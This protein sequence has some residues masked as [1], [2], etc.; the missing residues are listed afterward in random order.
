MEPGYFTFK[1]QSRISL[2]IAC[3]SL[4]IY[5]SLFAAEVM[6]DDNKLV[7]LPTPA[8]RIISLAPSL[9]ELLY[10]AGAGDKLVG[11]VEYSD[12]PAAAKSLPII[13]RFDMLDTERIL[14]LAPDLIVAWRS[15]NPRAAVRRL[16]E[17]GL[18]VYVAE[19][20]ELDSIPLHIEK[21]AILAGTE[22][23]ANLAAKDF[24]EKLGNLRSDYS[25]KAPVSTFYQVWDSPL[26]TAGGNELINDIIRLCGGE[27]IFADI[28]LVAPKVSE[29]AV[30][31]RNPNVIV[32]SGMDI[33]RPEWLDNWKRWPSLTATELNNLFFI[34]PE[35]L[36]R[37]TP[38]ALQGAELMCQY[39]DQARSRI[40]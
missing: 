29:E 6:D 26:I 32:A 31:V 11:V 9:T 13:G 35:L 25:P 16:Q 3:L 5:P 7:S 27:N 8:E 2:L 24:R 28:S 12:F 21:L 15:G 34:P 39:I 23:A 22:S 38:R 1:I 19:P 20:S 14:E 30:L 36:Q 40:N 4:L 10:A 37:H 33:E 17:L 18:T